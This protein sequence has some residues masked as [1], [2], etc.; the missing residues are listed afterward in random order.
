[1]G[2]QGMHAHQQGP[3]TASAVMWAHFV[4]D[5]LA[6]GFVK[7]TVGLVMCRKL[8][9]EASVSPTGLTK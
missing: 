6:Y 9:C 8:T 3:F 5:L 1:M 2:V 4:H 7:C